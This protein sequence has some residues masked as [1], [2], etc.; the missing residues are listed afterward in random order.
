MRHLENEDATFN[1]EYLV[2]GIADTSQRLTNAYF[3]DAKL[4]YRSTK[5]S[6]HFYGAGKTICDKSIITT[7]ELRKMEVAMTASSD[8]RLTVYI[9]SR[10]EKGHLTMGSPEVNAERIITRKYETACPSYDQVNSS[11]DRDESL[12]QIVP[13]S[14]E[15]EFE[16]DAK[17]DYQLNGSKTIQNKDGSETLVSWN[18]TRDCK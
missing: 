2:L 13:P 5:Y 11:V 3:A 6:E 10:G 7:T 4:N 14:F 17:S 9:T 16:L 8:K 18:L 1:V 15:I 12:V